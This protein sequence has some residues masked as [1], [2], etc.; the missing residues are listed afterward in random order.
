MCPAKNQGVAGGYQEVIRS[1]ETSAHIWTTGHITQK[2]A[3]LE[4]NGVLKLST[5][6]E[7]N[8]GNAKRNCIYEIIPPYIRA[9]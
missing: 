9:D 4:H 6:L 8:I 5:K 7:G 1:S 3:V 2:M